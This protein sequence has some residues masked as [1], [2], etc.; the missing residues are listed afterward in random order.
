M[1][2]YKFSAEEAFEKALEVIEGGFEGEVFDLTNEAFNTDYYIIGTAQAEESLEEYGVFQA[3]KEVQEYE[4]E[5]FGEVSTDISDPE[6]L[7]NMLFYIVGCETICQL[8]HDIDEYEVNEESK[9]KFISEIKK[10][11]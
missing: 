9:E 4:K 6:K 8:A 7:A 1:T 11:F 3:I 10:M 5:N 2:T